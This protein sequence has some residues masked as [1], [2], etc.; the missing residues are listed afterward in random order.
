MKRKKP[1]NNEAKKLIRS[2][3]I[4][5]LIIGIMGLLAIAGIIFLINFIF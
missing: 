1:Y 2:W 4:T 5:V 3:K